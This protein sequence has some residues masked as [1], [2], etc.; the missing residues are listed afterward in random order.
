M[1]S[2]S[3]QVTREVTQPQPWEFYAPVFEMSPI[4]YSMVPTIKMIQQMINYFTKTRAVLKRFF[5]QQENI[6][7]FLISCS[8]TALSNCVQIQR[9]GSAK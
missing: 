4:T 7:A 5:F 1:G 3:P 8:D 6:E 9:H 2:T